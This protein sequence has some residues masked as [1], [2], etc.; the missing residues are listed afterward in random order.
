MR[1]RDDFSE[2]LDQYHVSP[3]KESDISMTIL[4]GQE[5]LS[6]MVRSKTPFSILLREQARYISPCLWATQL[7]A[8]IVAILLSANLTGTHFEI[9]KILFGVTPVLA[10]FAVP[11]LLKSVVYGM[12]ELEGT[13]KN[14]AAKILAA[15]LFI[16]GSTNLVAITII[17]TSISIRHSMP[18]TQAVIYGLVPFNI[19]NGVNLLIFH[20][21]EIRSTTVASSISLCLI[22]LM[23]LMTELSFFAAMSQT[24]WVV[25]FVASTAFLLAELYGFIHSIAGKKEVVIQWS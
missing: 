22:A 11:E 16:I 17:I 12:S 3:G 8:I 18:F 4:L 14:S 7:A 6:R 13:C 1:D 20:L 9:Q 2:M 10:F 23:R 24:M 21:A 5:I 19:V 25:L 15:R